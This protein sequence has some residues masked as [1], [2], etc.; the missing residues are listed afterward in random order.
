MDLFSLSVSTVKFTWISWK[1]KSVLKG[2][3]D[4]ET[5]GVSDEAGSDVRFVV[6]DGD[7]GLGEGGKEEEAD[8]HVSRSDS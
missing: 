6:R 5:F 3:G 1:S 2:G 8:Y 4:E 7:G